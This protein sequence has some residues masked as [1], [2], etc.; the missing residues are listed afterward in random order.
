MN[1]SGSGISEHNLV[2]GELGEKKK[3]AVEFGIKNV[4]FPSFCLSFFLP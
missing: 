2:G 3:V 4:S 1:D